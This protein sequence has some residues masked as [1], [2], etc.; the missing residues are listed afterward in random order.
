MLGSE[1]I[2]RLPDF[3][4]L[5]ILVTDASS[6]AIGAVL[7]QLDDKGREHPVAF[8]SRTL[9][10]AE[11]RYC[12]TRREMLAVI[13]FLERFRHY[14]QRK[15]VLPTD[16]GSLRWLQSF[17]NPDGQWARWQQKLQ[18]YEFVMEHRPGRRHANADTLSWIPCPQCGR[19]S[20]KKA[21]GIVGA[22]ILDEADEMR[23]QQRD[24]SEIG[25]VLQAIQDGTRGRSYVAR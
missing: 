8:A 15:F 12:V 13:I 16:Y 23:R 24:D 21:E 3:N 1:P 9:T 20:S 19:Q 5:F 2:L 17:K 22:I 4:R 25:A 10:R 7:S 14:L 11:Q 6:I 18:Q